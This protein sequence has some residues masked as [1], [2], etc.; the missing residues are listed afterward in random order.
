MCGFVVT[1]DIH[2]TELML[3]KQK[4]RGPDAQA[5]YKDK[6]IGMGHALLDINGEKQIQPYKTKNGNYIVFNGEMYDTTI[7]NDTEYLAN[8]LETYGTDFLVHNDW[9]GSLVWYKPKQK[10]VFM[11]RDHFGAKPLWLY[12]KGSQFTATTS[13]RSIL[14]GEPSNK[15]NKLYQINAL[16]EGDECHIKDVTKIAP[17]QYITINLENKTIVKGNLWNGFLVEKRPFDIDVFKEKLIDS[18]SK[19]ARTKQKC[20]LFLSGGLDST[21]VLSIVKDLGLDLMVYICGYDDSKG[22]YWEHNAFR[23]EADLAIKTCQL[24]NVPYKVVTLRQD[25]MYHYDREWL[26]NARYPWTD[27]NRRAPRYMLAKH[28]A[29]DGCKVIFTGDSADEIVTG[30]I[31]HSKFWEK[32]YKKKKIARYKKYKWYPKIRHGADEW[33]DLLLGDLLI[34]SEQNILATDQ[35]CGMFGMESRPCFLGQNFVKWCYQHDGFFKFKQHPEWNTG[36]YKYLLREVMA[37]Y[38]PEHIRNKKKKV[39][40]S[41][42]WDNNHD[43]TVKMARMLDWQYLHSLL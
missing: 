24:W 32:D 18:I 35:S 13:L 1:T 40:W 30:Y 11:V 10:E 2:N 29:Q 34:T 28:A 7:P 41:S 12:Q 22:L 21:M 5:F 38:I 20:G 27:K 23:T 33:N 36:T 8:G 26:N 37:D 39:G 17:G 9:H 4:F 42:P 6:Y 16:M 43:K 15:H 3:K 19:I 14:S 31:H 25:L